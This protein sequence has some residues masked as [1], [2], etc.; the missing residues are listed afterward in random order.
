MNGVGMLER[1]LYGFG[2]CVAHVLFFRAYTVAAITRRL[3]LAYR[4]VGVSIVETGT[5]DGA[6]RTVFRCP[7]RSLGARWFGARWICHRKLDRVDDGYVTFL[8]R[9]RNL[10]YRRPQSCQSLPF[11][12]RSIHCYSEVE[13]PK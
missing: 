6:E 1:V 13:R 2:Y 12:E 3:R 7:Y 11:C 8:R 5:V 9:H 4:L 10:E